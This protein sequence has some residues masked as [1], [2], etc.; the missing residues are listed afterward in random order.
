MKKRVLLELILFG[1]VILFLGIVGAVSCADNQII[2]K[3]SSPTNAHVGDYNYSICYDQIF[4]PSYTGANQFNCTGTNTVLWTSSPSN[5]HAA[6]DSSTGYT[7]QICYGDLVCKS[8]SSP[9]GL[10]SYYKFENNFLDSAGSN[11]GVNNGVITFTSGISGQAA[12]FNGINSNITLPSV[13]GGTNQISI[14]T[15]LKVV[16]NSLNKYGTQAY[17]NAIGGLDNTAADATFLMTNSSKRVAFYINATNYTMT[18]DPTPIV[19][20]QW[21]HYCGVY[22]GT[23]VSIYRDGTFIASKANSGI[24]AANSLAHIGWWRGNHFNGTI[25]E[26]KIYNR[27]LSA[28]EISQEYALSNLANCSSFGEDYEAVVSLYQSSNSH[29]SNASDTNYPIKICCKSAPSSNIQGLHWEN[30]AGNPT[31]TSRT[32]GRVKAVVPGANLADKNISYEIYKDV[33]WWWDDNLAETNSRGDLVWIAGKNKS[34]VFEGGNYYFKAKYSGSSDWVS[35][36]GLSYGTLSVS[37]GMNIPPVAIINL[38]LDK[39]IYFLQE[40]LNFTQSSYDVDSYF[41]YTWDLGDGT[42]ISGNIQDRSNYN[43]IHAYTSSGQKNIKLTVTDEEGEISVDRISILVI[44]PDTSSNYILAYIDFPPVDLTYLGRIM[45]CDASST[46]AINKTVDTIEC[47]GGLCP[48]KTEGCKPP[49][50]NYPACQISVLNTPKGYSN[51]NFTWTFDPDI[52]AI[53]RVDSGFGKNL[54]DEFFVNPGKKHLIT[55]KAQI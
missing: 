14:C 18:E 1:F 51:I 3:L 4:G 34:N 21:Y 2:M 24:V 16:G 29:V 17:Y 36:Q 40:Q 47:I 33:K 13:F 39:Q 31:N 7:N 53:M 12:S 45:H 27:A 6:V 30:M 41:N 35:S 20:G 23:T 43:L 52:P 15:W 55:L 25:D 50:T 8:T 9:S 10:M 38:P 49:A 48:S 42:I 19:F 32:G 26:F 5:A 11:N 54:V 28:S 22:N 37:N 46:Y 44:N